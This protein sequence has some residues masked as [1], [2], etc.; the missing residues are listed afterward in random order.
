MIQILTTVDDIR[1]MIAIYENCQARTSDSEA[2]HYYMAR[3]DY[4]LEQLDE[5]TRQSEYMNITKKEV[6]QDG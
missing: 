4:L 3:I 2:W 5:M 6:S 1:E